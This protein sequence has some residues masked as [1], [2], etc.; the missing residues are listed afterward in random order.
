MGLKKY[1]VRELLKELGRRGVL[2]SVSLDEVLSPKQLVKMPDTRD[3]E[4]AV[5]QMLSTKI[6]DYLVHGPGATLLDANKFIEDGAE[7]YEVE[8]HIVRP[9]PEI[10][11]VMQ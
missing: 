6:A 1:N 3:R 2:V 7:R 11:G 4:M 9:A 5:K 8:L 10:L